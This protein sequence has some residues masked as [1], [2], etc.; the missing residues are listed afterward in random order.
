MNATE[1]LLE[2]IFNKFGTIKND[3]IQ[4][5][6]NRVCSNI[7]ILINYGRINDRFFYCTISYIYI[8]IC[9]LQQQG[10]CF[11]FVE[12]E[13]AT[14]MQKA[15]EVWFLLSMLWCKIRAKYTFLYLYSLW[16][17]ID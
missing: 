2:D 9:L 6:S 10:F 16:M 11:G 1:A 7:I 13:E 3:G 12:F 17:A 5:R 14:S 8:I 15:L 4:V